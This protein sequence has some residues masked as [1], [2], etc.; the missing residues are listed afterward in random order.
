MSTF[1]ELGLIPALL[2]ALT[3]LGYEEP[4][5]TAGTP[6]GIRY[7]CPRALILGSTSV[8]TLRRTS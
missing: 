1:A 5:R 7:R 8:A 2:E 3:A 4:T 6:R